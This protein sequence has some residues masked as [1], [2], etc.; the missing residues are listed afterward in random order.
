LSGPERSN[1]QMMMSRPTRLAWCA[2]PWNAQIMYDALR[3]AGK[4]VSVYYYN[5]G[6]GDRSDDPL[7]LE[8]MEERADEFLSNY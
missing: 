7:T 4:E 2:H 1:E 5:K 3:A 8:R 6:H